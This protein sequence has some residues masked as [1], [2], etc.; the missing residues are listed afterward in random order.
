LNL[1]TPIVNSDKQHDIFKLLINPQLYA[2]R[3]VINDW[4]SGFIDRDK[5]F[6][7][8]FQTTFESSFLEL[9]LNKILKEDNVKLNFSYHAPDFVCDKDG[10]EFCIEATIANPEQDGLPAYGFTES[11]ISFD[12]DFAEFNRKSIIRIA[13]SIIVKARKFKSSY[14]NL[15]HVLGKPFLLGLNSFDRPHSHFTGHR[16]IIAVLYG[17]YLNE[18][19]AIAENLSFIPQERMDFV[20]KSN[21]AEI[22]LGFFTTPEYEYISA[23]IYNPYA[24]WGKVRA[25]AEVSDTNKYCIFNAIY[26]RD[27]EMEESLI[28]DI[29][30]GIIKE[31]YKES[32]F[33]GLYV[34]HNPFA[35]YPMPA[36]L[37]NDPLIAHMIIDESG[38]LVERITGK[39]LLSRSLICPDSQTLPQKYREA[40]DNFIEN[41]K[42]NYTYKKAP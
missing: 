11:H 33:D 38:H 39:F 17:I 3:D 34:L 28:P 30:T 2:E 27:N 16:G 40:L 36:N 12:I 6:V 26:T 22:P 37:F 25:L 10:E 7:K 21:G 8:E 23:I 5:K 1:F 29:H 24:T 18:E 13:N 32:I 4:A 42:K 20:E 31:K 19:K 14:S 41:L 15:S 35:K 9:Y